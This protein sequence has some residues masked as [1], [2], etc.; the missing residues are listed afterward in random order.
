MTEDEK[1]DL[2]EQWLGLVYQFLRWLGFSEAWHFGA[3][4]L[5][6]TV[7]FLIAVKKK[8]QKP[9]VTLNQSEID[10]VRDA[11]SKRG[12]AGIIA[13]FKAGEQVGKRN[14]KGE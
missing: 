3:A 10:A 6:C 1:I 2:I 8:T 7:C 5:A 4:F 11:K 14:N 9:A 13:A 12:F